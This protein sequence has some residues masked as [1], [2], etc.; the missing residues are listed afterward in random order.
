[1][2]ISF[3]KICFSL[4]NFISL[5]TSNHHMPYKICNTSIKVDNNHAKHLKLT[6]TK[7]HNV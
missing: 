7:I 1:M 6:Q 3:F 2:T 5:I 4:N